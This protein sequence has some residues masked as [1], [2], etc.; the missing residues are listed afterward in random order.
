MRLI[1]AVFLAV[2]SFG[3]PGPGMDVLGT[4][5]V[6]G[7]P[8]A[9]RRSC[10]STRLVRRRPR[11]GRRSCSISATSADPRSAF[12]QKPFTPDTLGRVVRDVL[13]DVGTPEQAA[14]T[15]VRI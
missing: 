14:N 11:Y 5:T 13:D 8:I 7:K 2:L 6:R 3:R 4:A 10:G 1:L 12:I 15:S 9:A